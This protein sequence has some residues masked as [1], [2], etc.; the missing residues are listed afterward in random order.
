MA[1][2]L[3]PPA[4]LLSCEAI[5]Y[6]VWTQWDKL[7]LYPAAHSQ[8]PCSPS[9]EHKS[10]CFHL[11]VFCS[12]PQ[13]PRGTLIRSVVSWLRRAALQ[14]WAWL[15]WFK[16]EVSSSMT[17]LLQHLRKCFTHKMSQAQ[18]SSF[19]LCQTM[20]LNNKNSRVYVSQ[21]PPRWADLLA[22]GQH[23]SISFSAWKEAKS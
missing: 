12:L 23:G 18:R 17:H 11:R 20:S 2:W 9:L 13:L 4:Q 19:T 22:G 21:Y 10:W 7:P 5:S 16:T 14:P 3:Q 8:D 6:P 15:S 1:M